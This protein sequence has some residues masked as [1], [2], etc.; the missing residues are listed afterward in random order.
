MSNSDAKP[1]VAAKK[2]EDSMVTFY[3]GDFHGFQ[4]I[5]KDFSGFSLIFMDSNG[6]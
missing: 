5:L 2:T 6:F 1:E 4:W 3:M